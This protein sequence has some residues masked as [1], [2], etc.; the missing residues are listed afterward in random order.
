MVLFLGIYLSIS[1]YIIPHSFNQ[2]TFRNLLY[3][4]LQTSARLYYW[5]VRLAGT[6]IRWCKGTRKLLCKEKNILMLT[7]GEI[8]LPPIQ[9]THIYKNK[10]WN[11]SPVHKRA[12]EFSC[13]VLVLIMYDNNVC[14]Y[15]ILWPNETRAAK[16]PLNSDKKRTR[17]RGSEGRILSTMTVGKGDTCIS[18][19]LQ[20]A[21]S[22]SNV[23][24]QERDE[25]WAAKEEG[26]ERRILI[27]YKIYT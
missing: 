7:S 24:R 17:H 26:N 12:F 23:Q 6:Q 4:L 22:K 2:K 9:P 10:P 16:E 8:P 18:I 15:C 3:D 14:T 20:F 13:S 5:P 27:E 11:K 21:V 1:V 19:T 25:K